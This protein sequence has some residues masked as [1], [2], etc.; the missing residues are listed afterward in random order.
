MTNGQETSLDVNELIREALALERGDLQKHRILV[1]AEPNEQLP[2]VLGN[3]VQLQQV[4]LNL[5]TNAIDAMAAKDEPRIL[6]VKSEAY[7]GDSVMVSVVDTGTGVSSRKTSIGY[8]IRS[9]RPNPTAWA[10]AC[11]S[12]ERSSRP[13]MAGC[14]LP[15]TL[16]VAPYFNLPCTPINRCPPAPDPGRRNRDNAVLLRAPGL[17]HRYLEHTGH[18]YQLGKRSGPHLLHDLAAM[19]LE[20]DLADA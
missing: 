10:W 4:L 7:D 13:T 6:C 1:Q 19:N 15:R 2:E 5:I 18:S 8:S 14:G 20:R 12:A 9:S 3:R 16:P 11:R 17:G